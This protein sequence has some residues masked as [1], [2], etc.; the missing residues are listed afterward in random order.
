MQ[1][2]WVCGGSSLLRELRAHMLTP[3]QGKK[4][5][6]GEFLILI[7]HEIL[8][9]KV[10]MLLMSVLGHQLLPCYNC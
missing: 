5:G 4:S 2:A 8:K 7:F 9:E 3:W 10:L 6:V 1:G